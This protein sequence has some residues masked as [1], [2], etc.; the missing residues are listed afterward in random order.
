MYTGLVYSSMMLRDV[1]WYE[2]SIFMNQ[3]IFLSPKFANYPVCLTF[4]MGETSADLTALHFL[5]SGTKKPEMETCG[6]SRSHIKASSRRLSMSKN[7]DVSSH[8]FTSFKFYS[9]R[10]NGL[11]LEKRRTMENSLPR[12]R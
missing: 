5:I 6:R 3:F 1:Q 7:G 11:N 2:L 12:Q 9:E 8:F 10:E 4:E